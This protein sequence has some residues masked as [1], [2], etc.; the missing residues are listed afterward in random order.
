MVDSTEKSPSAKAVESLAKT[1]PPNDYDLQIRYRTLSVHIDEAHNDKRAV[2]EDPKDPAT[3]IRNIDVHLLTTDDVLNRFSTSSKMGL[4]NAAVQ[5][6]AKSGGKNIISPPKTNHWKKALNYVFGGFNFL[7]WIAFI[8]T[9]LSYK[10]LGEP[11][12]AVFNLGVAVLLLLVIVVSA[13]FYAFVDWH[14]SRIMNSIKTLIAEEATVIRDGEQQAVPARDVVVGDLVVLHMGDRVPADIRLVQASSDLRFDRS[15]LTGESDMVPGALESTSDNALETRNL[16]LTSTFVVQGNCTGV[17]FAIGDKSVMGCIVAMSGETKFKLTTVQKEVWFFTKIVS[18]LAL[19][20]F[21]ISIIVW[22]A[23]LRRSF[24]GYE[25]AS[26]AIINSIG[27]LTAFVPQGLP[28]CVA[29]SLTIIAKRMAKRNVLVKNLATIET[30][31]CMSVL[32]SDKTGTLTVGRMSLQN[33]AF[34][35]DQFQVDEVRKEYSALGGPAAPEAF[36]ALHQIARLCN[37]AKFDSASVHLPVEER[38]IKG[39][40]TDTAVLRFSETL[41]IPSLGVDTASL[42][43]AHEKLFEIPFNSRNKWM[44]TVVR[45]KHK[46]SGSGPNTWMLVKG[47][48][49]VLFPTCSSVMQS[50]GS[51]LPMT[52]SNRNRLFALQEDWSNQGQRVL[53]LCRRS[54][55]DVNFNLETMSGNEVEKMMYAELQGLTLVGLVGI[56]DPPRADVPGAVEAIRRAGVRMFMVT[57]DFKL[58][59]LAI[60][61]Q[62]GIV[63]QD[64]VDTL[65]HMRSSDTAKH[66]IDAPP[67][68]IRPSD[69]DAPR[70]LILTGNDIES[71]TPGDWNIV[72]GH[73]TEIVFARTTPE[74]KLRIVEEVKA[75]GDNTV[76]VTG[77]GVNDAPAL[78]ASDIGVAMGSG[79]DVAKEAAAMVLLNNDLSSIVVAIEMGRLVFDNLKKVMIYLM[80]AGTYTEFMT[81]FATVFLGMQLALSSYLQVCFSITNDVVMSISLMYEKPEADL[82][83][84][85]PRNARTD[86]LTDWKFFFQIYLFI[87]LMMWPCAMSMWFLYMKQQGLRF[88]DVILVY[89]NWQDGY[90]G[91]SL[92]QL[93]HFVSVGQCIYYV[94]MV[95]MQYGGL[96]SVRNRRVSILQSNPLWGPR[97]NLVVPMGM[98]GT[99]LIAVVNLY[100]HGLQRVFG[101]TPIP[102]MFWGIPFSFALAILIMDEIRKLL[103]RTYPKS[104]IA[105]MA[106]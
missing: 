89:S 8:V 4:D 68:E 26:G 88:Y 7:M 6:R 54:L 96:L 32:C 24:P 23:W 95:F 48:P 91:Y 37:G 2:Q 72:V 84:R 39:D 86:R 61:K 36:R 105:K 90:H 18:A 51:T 70:A 9:I 74:Q 81:V 15:L 65:E 104:F 30:L 21:C 31:G 76:A 41:V 71:L 25:T 28:V 75:R 87:G 62:V 5:R 1:D 79:S 13:T 85:K 46:P 63:T 53:A 35:D 103:V 38:T 19:S 93:T 60:A 27:C 58:T 101:T 42:M 50:D 3:A 55:N 106:W 33:V 43:D 82:M 10:P 67:P 97:R 11:N 56:R 98:I 99:A 78:R 83:L 45:E 59:A 29:L 73:Y 102:G 12:P 34:F 94:T 44:L 77:D 80:P 16:A 66:F 57:G 40:A 17:V 47:A 64:K 22:A 14:A 52:P 49:D 20:L 92:E 69:D 100:G